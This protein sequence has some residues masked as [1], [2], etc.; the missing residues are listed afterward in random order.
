MAKSLP[1]ILPSQLRAARSLLDWS[2]AECAKQTGLSPETI[3]NIEHGTY[4]AHKES[5]AKIFE[6]FTKFGVEF[7]CHELVINIPVLDDQAAQTA[8]V[9]YAGAV[10]VA[11]AFQKG[12]AND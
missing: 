4:T 10:I 2:R 9:T 3:K 5:C 6:A 7:I 11:A 12:E 8:T 1:A